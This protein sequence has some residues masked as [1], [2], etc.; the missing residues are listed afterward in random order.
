MPGHKVEQS[1]ATG[2]W[3]EE[4][5]AMWDSDPIIVELREYRKKMLAMFDNDIDRYS[6]SLVVVGYACAH[7]YIS[8]DWR[9]PHG[10]REAELPTDL[11][12]LIPDREDF[13]NEVRMNRAVEAIGEPNLDAYNE[14]ARRRA[15]ILG[16]P[17]ETF[18]V[19][20]EEVKE[21]ADSIAR[22]KVERD[23]QWRQMAQ[24]HA[25]KRDSTSRS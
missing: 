1:S 23:L 19:T 10:P 3:T 2:A 14:D 11:T 25:A 15:L 18:V 4:F 22:Y 5:A 12:G 6:R 20:A 16:F 8:T 13:I 24:E 7:K 9:D 17:A 21:I